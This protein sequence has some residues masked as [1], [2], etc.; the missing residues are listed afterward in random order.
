MDA[1]EPTTAAPWEFE[2]CLRVPILPLDPGIERFGFDVMHTPEG[3]RAVSIGEGCASIIDLWKVHD[4]DLD[5]ISGELGSIDEVI[6]DVFHER[7][8]PSF[9]VLIVERLEL[10]M[11]WRARGLGRIILVR[12]IAALGSA[13]EL[14]LIEPSPLS[15]RMLTPEE[16]ADGRRRLAKH[17]EPLGFEHYRNGI[18][19][20]DLRTQHALDSL[21]AVITHHEAHEGV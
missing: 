17:W 18:Y 7:W 3:C 6:D 2:L 1:I 19:I 10:E 12:I 21:A 15:S 11:A 14:V 16:R 8:T 9:P 20:L 5:A 13:S 4:G